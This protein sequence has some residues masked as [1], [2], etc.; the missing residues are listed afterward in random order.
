MKSWSRWGVGGRERSRG[1]L[2]Q[3]RSCPGRGEAAQKSCQA[4]PPAPHAATILWDTGS[5][6]W[7]CSVSFPGIS[8][9]CVS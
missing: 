6:P 9:T 5:Q 3:R 8:V 2:P 4:P 7:R 1:L